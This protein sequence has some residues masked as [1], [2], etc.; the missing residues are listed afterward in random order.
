MLWG[1]LI[2]KYVIIYPRH[3][4]RKLHFQLQELII[5]VQGLPSQFRNTYNETNI[6]CPGII[7]K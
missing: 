4:P 6:P 1:L 3:K 2:I 5:I 7:F